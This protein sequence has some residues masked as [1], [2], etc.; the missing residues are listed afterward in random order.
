MIAWFT[1]HP[2]AANLLMF[3]LLVGGVL[4]ASHMRKEI[5]PKLPSNTITISVAYD[6]RTAQQ[7]DN[8]IAQKVDQALQGVAGIKHIKSQSTQHML[9]VTISKKLDYSMERL[10]SDV[11][12]RVESIYDWPQQ[13]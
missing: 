13:A 6:G 10:F 4:S 2:I 12:A 7:V 8:E 5:I 9:N 11:K 3:A 1:R